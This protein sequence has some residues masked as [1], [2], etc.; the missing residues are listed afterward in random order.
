MYTFKRVAGLLSF[1]VLA[2]ILLS[3]WASPIVEADGDIVFDFKLKDNPAF[4]NDIPPIGTPEHP[5][6]VHGSGTFKLDGDLD[7]LEYELKIEAHDLLADNWYHLSVTEVNE[8]Y[9]MKIVHHSCVNQT[10]EGVQP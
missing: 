7:D 3:V 2:V 1:A 5:D 9:E 8:T 10:H 6:E 4:T